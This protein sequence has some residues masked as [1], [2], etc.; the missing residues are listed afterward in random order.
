MT[1]ARATA[2]LLLV[3][4]MLA[5]GCG[6]SAK[7]VDPADDLALIHQ[8]S[9]T[10]ADLP[11]YSAAKHEATDD[12]PASIRKSFA[13]CMKVPATVFDDT[14]NSQKLD[15]DN[16]S[17]GEAA[18]SSE[19]RIYGAKN[20]VDDRWQQVAKPA[21]GPCLA[22]LF[23]NGAKLGAEA[24]VTFGASSGTQF[25]V[26]VGPRSVGYSVKL[27]LTAGKQTTVF[28][29]DVVFAQRDRAVVSIESVDVGAQ[30]DRAFQI[31]LTQKVY[32][33]LGA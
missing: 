8:A 1:A 9:L 31:A 17:K 6:S 28:Y 21:T 33:R 3:A 7:K 32:D 12:V 10:A 13:A 5:S 29:A 22:Q 30:S 24:G 16:F 26:G 15:S 20:D 19:L 23:E 27:T 4:C 25:E 11:G 18:V 2:T 14:P